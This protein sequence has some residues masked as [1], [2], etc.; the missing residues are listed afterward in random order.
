MSYPLS[1]AV[2]AGDAT[3]ASHYNNLR[4]DALYFG[5]AADDAVTLAALLERYESRLE[6]ERLNTDQLRVPAS[7]SE[8]VSLVIAG[9][10]VQAAANVDLAA[11]NKP[12]GAAGTYYIFANRADDS[13]TFTLTVSTSITEGE[14]QR[15]I[16]RFY[17]D[18]SKIIRDSIQTELSLQV[19]NLLYYVEP[20]VCEGRLTVSTGVSVP[21]AD[22]SASS[23]VYFTPH[24]GNRVA[25]YVPN[26]GWRLYTFSELTLDIS[27]A[28]TDT[29]LDI[30]IYDNAGTLTLAYEAWSNDTLRATAITRQDGI[31]CKSSAL[32]YR[33]LGTVRTSDAGEV[34]DTKEMRF[35]WNYYNRVDRALYRH[36]STE[37][38]TYSVREWRPFNNSTSNRLQFVIGVDE[39]PVSLDFHAGSISDS[40]IIRS[41]GIGLDDDDLP[42]T[43]CVWGTIAVSVRAFNVCAYNGCPGIGYHY[44]QLLEIGYS[45]TPVTYY[46]SYTLNSV[47][48][49]H[50]GAVGKVMA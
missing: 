41:I 38:W 31:Y 27:A 5:R 40:S 32:N 36:D 37:S 25:L 43:D 2:F 20:Q 10:M 24:T 13:T 3:L 34:S 22:V 8:P 17:W 11:E 14:N 29:N 1:S 49:V 12:S 19:K 18:G 47:E 35:V 45:A 16:G 42:S 46:G 44:L 39:A 30:F 28:A 21:A 48:V 6:I 4:S 23:N 15:R 50:S 9:Y 26:Y 7:T 33:Y